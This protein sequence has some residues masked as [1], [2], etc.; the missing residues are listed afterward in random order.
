MSHVLQY[1]YVNA[2][3]VKHGCSLDFEPGDD[4]RACL[5]RSTIAGARA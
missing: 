4:A 2:P 5:K 3:Y 1:V